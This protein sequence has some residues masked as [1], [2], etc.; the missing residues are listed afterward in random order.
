LYALIYL[1]FG[2]HARELSFSEAKETGLRVWR[3]VY[4]DELKKQKDYVP[5]RVE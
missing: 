4:E 3:T 5:Y 2:E 1:D